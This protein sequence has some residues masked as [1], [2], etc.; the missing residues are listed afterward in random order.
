VQL[1]RQGQAPGL[2]IASQSTNVLF[3]LMLDS[4]T[5]KVGVAN[6]QRIAVSISALIFFW[7]AFALVAAIARKLPWFVTP[8]LA[9]LTYGTMFNGGMFNYYLAAGLSL[10]AL[11]VLW[12]AT[13]WDGI[14]VAMLL[15][16]AWLAQ[17]VPVVWAVVVFGYVAA[18]RLLTD[19]HRWWLFLISVVV[20]LGVRHFILT[21]WTSAWEWRQ[22]IHA[23]GAGQAFTL[24]HHYRY[25][26][27][28]VLAI[29]LATLV[30]LARTLSLKRMLASIPV[31]VYLLCVLG[32]FLLP[33]T[34]FF[35]PFKAFA[36][37]G[38]SRTIV[39]SAINYRLGWLAG[40]LL[41]PLL[42]Q[43]KNPVW[44]ARAVM[45]TALIY[46]SFLYQDHRAMNKLENR[47]NELVSTL[48]ADSRVIAALYYPTPV[49]G[50]DQSMILDRACIRRCYSFNNYEPVT[51]EFRVRAR[52]GNSIVSWSIDSPNHFY[53]R[54]IQFFSSQ[55]NGVL[56][57]IYGCGSGVTD[58]CMRGLHFADM[59]SLK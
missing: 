5:G 6:A 14:V 58:V 26:T 22:I 54:A 9:I 49:D 7:G 28:A 33:D 17:P 50:S 52:P 53:G 47:V 56:Y 2:W 34:I 57:Y 42:A 24:G 21:H 10:A 19:R 4:L 46:F 27:V 18:A 32:P 40:V 16:L 41:C 55:P 12:R 35:P 37:S 51:E 1:I 11:A 43:V 38:L 15:A 3:D 45:V 23:T 20:L 39:F 59:A 8:L 31:Q 13:M 36:A 25:V 29:S 30:Y 48:P 44:F